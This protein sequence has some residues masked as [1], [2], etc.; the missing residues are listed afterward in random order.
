M[1]RAQIG[2]ECK[3]VSGLVPVTRR[4][5]L[6]GKQFFAGADMLLLC[7]KVKEGCDNVGWMGPVYFVTDC[8]TV[9][10]YGRA[11]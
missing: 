1:K 2:N 7:G 3:T 6:Q 11:E 10:E 9:P 4:E 5:R 8:L